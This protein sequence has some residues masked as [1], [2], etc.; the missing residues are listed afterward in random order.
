MTGT[1]IGRLIAVSPAGVSSDGHSLWVCKCDCGNTK[2]IA[3]NNFREKGG[4]KSCGCLR[5]EAQRKRI[6][7]NGAWNDGKS[8]AINNG[9][10]VYK[11]RHSWAKAAIR[12]YGNVC[13]VCGWSKARCDVHHKNQK[14]K[15]G[16]NTIK[17][18][19]VLCPNCHRKETI[20]S[21]VW[22]GGK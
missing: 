9:E 6:S 19:K 12:H 8:Y 4:T 10:R 11:T 22:A 16:L 5:S 7:K 3:S 2:T 21:G 18:A 1:R 13:Q 20:K 14:A 15:G 17:N